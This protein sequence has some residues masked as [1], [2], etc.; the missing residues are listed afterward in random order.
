MDL[1]KLKKSNQTSGFS[2]QVWP[3]GEE[4]KWFMVEISVLLKLSN[5][6]CLF[7]PFVPFCN[8]GGA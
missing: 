6:I 5:C 7:S 8:G 3:G 1:M 4:L 2:K